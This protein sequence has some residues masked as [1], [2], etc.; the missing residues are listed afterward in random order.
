MAV[1]DSM[2]FNSMIG[3]LEETASDLSNFL[4]EIEDRSYSDGAYFYSKN[5][6]P[7]EDEFREQFEGALSNLYKVINKLD[8]LDRKYI[9][10]LDASKLEN[11]INRLE[12]L[13]K[14]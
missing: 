3:K 5:E 13:M 2:R 7:F 8:Y 6:T 9:K 10:H 14:K 12:R 4:E 11:R 1:N